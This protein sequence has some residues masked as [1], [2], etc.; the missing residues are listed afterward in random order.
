M[1]NR[2]KT[3]FRLIYIVIVILKYRLDAILVELD[4]LKPVQWT[5]RCLPTRWFFAPPTAPVAERLHQALE[6][7]GPLFVKF[8][9]LLSTRS[10]LLPEPILKELSKLQDKVPSFDGKVA[11]QIIENSLGKPIDI[12]F[13]NFDLKP[14]AS[15]SIAQVHAATTHEGKAVVVKV[16]RPTIHRTIRYDLSILKKIATLLERY[17]KKAK[18]FKPKAMVQ[19]FQKTILDELDLMREAANA[20][21]LRRHFLHSDVLY[22]PKIY[23]SHTEGQVLTMERVYGLSTTDIA[24]L[25][26]QG[27][28]LK[29]LAENIIHIFFTQVFRDCFFHA[30]LHPG[31]L[32]IDATQPDKPRYIA[33]D[34]GIVGTLNTADQR[35]LAENFL[36]FFKRDYRKVATLHVESG[37]VPA[38]TR[39]EEFES[40]I[41]T[42]SEPLFEKPL[43]DMSFGKTLL[44]LFQTAERFDMNIQPQF[45]LLQK[46]L[47]TVEG[48]SRQLYPDLDLWRTAKPFLEHWMQTQM[49]LKSVLRKIRQNG[50]YWVERF[51]E[52]PDRLLQLLDHV[53]R[54]SQEHLEKKPL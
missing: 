12:L 11:Q 36:A 20:S 31:N 45:L 26:A 37:W 4:I 27:V 49:G 39:V 28:N 1:L 25:K 52:I 24:G 47:I 16:L 42:V 50:P 54:I 53:L 14:L 7:L 18:R 3:F 46:T 10:D 35:Y 30:D 48:L 23:W 32:F 13:A 22:I 44:R 17:S 5:L 2:I 51:P 21:Q 34:F 6:T 41:R 19:E 9:Q 38:S 33:V 43:K 8:G 15:A 29:K 40:A